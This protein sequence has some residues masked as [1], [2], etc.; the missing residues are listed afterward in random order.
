M[1]PAST[2]DGCQL[3]GFMKL[4]FRDHDDVDIN[5]RELQGIAV[6]Q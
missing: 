3:C 1:N 4:D 6:L 5:P 2:E